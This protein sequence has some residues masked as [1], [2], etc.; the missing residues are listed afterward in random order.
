MAS[1][2]EEALNE[3]SLDPNVLQKLVGDRS[4]SNVRSLRLV[5]LGCEPKMPYGPNGHTAQLFLDLLETICHQKNPR[6]LTILSIKVYD[7][8]QGEYP[9]NEAEW[10]SYD[11][12]LLPGS[13]SSAYDP[14]PWILELQRVL[15]EHVVAKRRKTLGICFGHQ[16]LAQSF[17]DGNVIAVP[18]G[19]RAGR[20][21]S[22]HTE[23][24]TN[25]LGCET[26][27][28]FYT[29]GDMVEQLPSCAVRLGGSDRVPIE[30]AAY[31]HEST[32]YAITFQAHPEFASSR[33]LGP[34][35]TLQ[36]IMDAMEER[37]AIAK[38]SRAKAGEDAIASFGDVQL[39]SVALVTRVAE[40]FGWL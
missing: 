27:D 16:V 9:A 23:E 15:Q 14:D 6:D 40:L 36:L 35:R 4:A 22:I 31:Y 39:P 28:L 34:Y 11:G 7:V 25:L 10:D 30:A 20:L 37:G 33:D 19:A 5:M 8:Q 17:P 32:P 2:Y 21:T 24:G 38:E 26:A 29:H 18:S 3:A 1:L 12:V 13:F